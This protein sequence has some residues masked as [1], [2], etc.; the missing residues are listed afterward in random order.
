MLVTSRDFVYHIVKRHQQPLGTLPV[1]ENQEF[2]NDSETSLFLMSRSSQ[3]ILS[4]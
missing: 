4:E 1:F 3:F 2:E